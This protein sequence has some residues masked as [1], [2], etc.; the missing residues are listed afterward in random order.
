MS[1]RGDN[2]QAKEYAR[3]EIARSINRIRK[4]A[5]AGKMTPLNSKE[6]SKK[7][8]NNNELAW[9]DNEEPEDQQ[10]SYY[11]VIA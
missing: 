8:K 10:G 11:C 9:L 1:G 6:E 7:G 5:D 4:E 3:T 2:A